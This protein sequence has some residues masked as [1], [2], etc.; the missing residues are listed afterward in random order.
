ML[1]KVLSSISE[2]SLACIEG[3]PNLHYAIL[4]ILSFFISSLLSSFDILSPAFSTEA[5]EPVG[6]TYYNE[7]QYWTNSSSDTKPKEELPS[8]LILSIDLDIYNR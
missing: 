7:I 8:E 1:R 4:L 2:F 3:F 5:C 6:K